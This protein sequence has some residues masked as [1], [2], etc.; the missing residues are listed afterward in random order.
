[1]EENTAHTTAIGEQRRLLLQ[2]GEAAHPS[3]SPAAIVL[4]LMA[5][6][7]QAPGSGEVIL[8]KNALIFYVA[9]ATQLA[10]S[11]KVFYTQSQIL[12]P[13]RCR[14]FLSMLFCFMNTVTLAVKSTRAI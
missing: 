2:Y 4:A 5:V 8:L 6:R 11:P 10:K 13:I 14:N 3:A 1:L 9:A 12:T 7:C